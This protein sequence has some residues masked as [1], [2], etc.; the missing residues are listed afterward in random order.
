MDGK[1]SD[2][3]VHS[4]LVYS[5]FSVFPSTLQAHTL[6]ASDY[7]LGASLRL[8]TGASFVQ[9]LR[10]NS[11]PVGSQRGACSPLCLLAFWAIFWT[12]PS[13]WSSPLAFSLPPPSSRSL[14]PFSQ[15]VPWPG[16]GT[17]RCWV[18]A[19]GSQ[20]RRSPSIAQYYI[21]LLSGMINTEI[22]IWITKIIKLG[23]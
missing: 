3:F 8:R 23:N 19:V 12:H 2:S 17:A 4:L 5:N 14:T 15:P 11:S 1:R 21:S 18:L 16:Y 13:I 10:L 22:W 7:K 20:G 6:G 9:I